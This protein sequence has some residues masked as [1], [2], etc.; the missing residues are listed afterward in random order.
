MGFLRLL[1]ALSVVANH[2]TSIFGIDFVGGRIAVQAFFMISGFYMAL[3]LNEKY[4]GK[5]SNYFLFI[6]NRIL[7][8]YPTYWVVAMFTLFL[9][10]FLLHYQHSGNK[11]ALWY[12]LN[13]VSFLDFKAIIFIIITNIVVLGQDLYLFL[14]LDIAHKELFFTSNFYSTTP[15]FWN[16][17]IIPPGWSI[18]LELMFYLIAPFILRSKTSVIII[19]ASLCLIL[20]LILIY[21]LKLSDDPWNYRF[22]PT[23]LLFFLLG[24][25]S[26]N[27]KNF[28]EKYH[29]QLIGY[30]LIFL[31]LITTLFYTLFTK[32]V[33]TDIF[34]YALIFICLPLLF[35]LFSSNKIDA[36]IG[37]LSY[38]VY[39]VHT[40]IILIYDSFNLNLPKGP[41]V[42][43]ISIFTSYLLIKLLIKPIEKYRQKR[44]I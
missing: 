29:N 42:A 33:I 18:S 17:L 39:L 22:F 44:L 11:S 2:S 43:V 5:N 34:Y 10:Y 24:A 26:F 35:K 27:A 21:K 41:V 9:S 13:Y 3:I 12:F 30:V 40:P 20:R 16:F 37:E 6:S 23:E 19:I 8:I 1:L 31:L 14:G 4:V 38:P 28:F 15:H 32:S 36:K 25:L 7:R